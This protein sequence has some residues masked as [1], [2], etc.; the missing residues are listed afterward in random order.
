MEVEVTMA[1]VMPC[2]RESDEKKGGGGE[3]DCVEYALGMVRVPWQGGEGQ[4]GTARKA[5]Q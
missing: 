1:I 5:V 3:E 4:E 2:S